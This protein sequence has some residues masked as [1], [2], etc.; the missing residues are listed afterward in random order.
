MVMGKI[1]LKAN[2]KINLSLD[3]LGRRNDGY[4]NV[5]MIMQSIDLHDKITIEEV[6]EGIEIEC[7]YPWVP[8]D[9]SNTAYK[10]AD[11]LMNEYKIKQ[12]VKIKI[13]KY[14]P[15]AAGLA[16][17]SSD[18]AAVLKGINSLF[19]LNLGNTELMG[20]GKIIGADVPYC[21]KGGTMLA[22]GIGEVLT[23]LEHLPET[24]IVLVKPRISVSTSWA[25]QNLD[26][27]NL[28][29]RPDTDTLINAINNHDIVT[30]AKKMKNVLEDV[31]I[32]R[33]GIINEIKRKLIEL[34]AAGSMMSGSGP[35]VFGIFT[36][37][38]SARKAYSEI[39]FNNWECYLT[40]TI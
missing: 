3:V 26:I 29:K 36:D 32:G 20:Y 13:E 28:S 18:A 37:S 17:G 4:H 7:N 30:V 1:Q 11:L 23:E 10:A 16:G 19:N 33:H 39:K 22:E 25:Y 21:I 24:Q 5:K 38:L 6:D 8:T 2:A 35:T 9:K 14:I 40:H 15:V 31:T 27:N 34:G 12:G